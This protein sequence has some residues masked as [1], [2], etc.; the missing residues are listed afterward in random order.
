MTANPEEGNP[1]DGSPWIFPDPADPE[2]EPI[3][4]PAGQSFS[5]VTFFSIDI[6]QAT[7]IN[8]TATVEAPFDVNPSNN[9]VTAV[10]NV[11][12]NSGGGGGG[13]GGRP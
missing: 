9:T 3:I 1:I 12:V 7:T 4:I 13:P 2:A 8:W 6:G 11:R 10:S 5:Q